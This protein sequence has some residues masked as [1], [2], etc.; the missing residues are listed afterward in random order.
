MKKLMHILLLSCLKATELIEK[1][2]FFKLSFKERLQL[3]LHKM[4]CD[5][6]SNY[7]KQSML[8]EKAIGLHQKN[9]QI[10]IDIKQLKEQISVKLDKAEN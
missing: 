9:Q 1:R 5:A 6:C 7:E 3:K 10:G 2:F 4:V 8:L